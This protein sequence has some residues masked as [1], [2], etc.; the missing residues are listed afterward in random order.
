M[1]PGQAVKRS[2]DFISHV[3]LELRLKPTSGNVPL[4]VKSFHPARLS[5]M[6]LCQ[7]FLKKMF[8]IRKVIQGT[9]YFFISFGTL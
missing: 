6:H 7:S 9:E 2:E 8:S 3:D 4:N 5:D 1:K